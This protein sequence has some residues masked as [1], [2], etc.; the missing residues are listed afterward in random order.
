MML[1]RKPSA[2]MRKQSICSKLALVITKEHER[3]LIGPEMEIKRR[4]EGMITDGIT[5]DET[6]PFGTLLLAM[7]KDNT[8]AWNTALSHLYE[9]HEI[10]ES[11][12]PGKLPR[13]KFAPESESIA[14]DIL[15]QKYLLGDPLSKYAS[16]RI[17]YGYCELRGKWAGSDCKNFLDSMH[18]LIRP[19]S[20]RPNYAVDNAPVTP[21]NSLF[22]RVPPFHSCDSELTVHTVKHTPSLEYVI[23]D[24]SFLPLEKYYMDTFNIYKKFLIQ[25]K[26]CG[27]FIFVDSLKYKLCGQACK[28][29]SHANILFE[30]KNDESISAV[31]RMILAANAHWYNGIKKLQSSNIFSSEEIQAYEEAK[32]A[33]L[34]EKREKRKALKKGKI[35]LNEFRDWLL[36]QENRAHEELDRLLA[37]KHQ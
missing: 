24:N 17:W 30:R 18:N 11:H 13:N 37:T 7:D 20:F 25:C 9:A 22:R 1:E 31:D 33:Y 16:A 4:L 26:I 14:Y 36:Q 10:L 12:E 35:S 23:V 19:F 32:D 8:G 27:R 5:F 28:K 3:I 2:M 15:N 34:S 21:S 29:Q 6:R